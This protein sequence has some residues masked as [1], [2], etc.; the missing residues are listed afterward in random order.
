MIDK[1]EYLP[2]LPSNGL[3]ATTGVGDGL[4]Y[5]SGKLRY[6]LLDP[7]A[8]EGLVTVL[9]SGAQEYAPHN[10]QKGM[11]WESVLASLKRHIAEWEKG[12]DLDKKSG[13]PHV[14]HI[15][16]NAHFLSAFRVKFPEGDDRYYKKANV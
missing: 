4:R 12:E 8:I 3:V 6:E 15:Q 13:L 11:S 1:Y 16:A 5:N 10:W 2:P 14:D 9:T 7:F